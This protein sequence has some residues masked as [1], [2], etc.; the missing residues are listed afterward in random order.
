MLDK[1]RQNSSNTHELTGSFL[2]H[3]SGQSFPYVVRYLVAANDIRWAAHIRLAST[4]HPV[5]AS[6]ASY[7][8]GRGEPRLSNAEEVR[9]AALSAMC[10]M[11]MHAALDA[12]LAARQERLTRRLLGLSLVIAALGS[13]AWWLESHSI[14]S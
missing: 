1:N 13:G 4:W 8:S 7:P 10:G 2:D 14:F 5:D 11:D 3:R 6:L 9:D 12:A